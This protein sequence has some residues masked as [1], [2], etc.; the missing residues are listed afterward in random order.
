MIHESV[1]EKL[2]FLCEVFDLDHDRRIGTNDMRYVLQTQLH[3]QNKITDYV[4][5][6]KEK[7]SIELELHKLFGAGKPEGSQLEYADFQNFLPAYIDVYQ[8]LSIF[9]II[10][11]PNQEREIIGEVL[12]E[13]SRMKNDDTYYVISGGWYRAWQT[14]V[15]TCSA[16]TEFQRYVHSNDVRTPKASRITVEEPINIYQPKKL[17]A[18]AHKPKINPI[19]IKEDWIPPSSSTSPSPMPATETESCLDSAGRPG[20]IDNADLE[21][22]L[23]GSLKDGLMVRYIYHNAR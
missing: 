7:E 16:T 21:G 20:E 17:P 4:C 19:K 3:M 1:T 14:F 6:S 22:Y 8:M 15:N 12:R 23:P 5:S 2:H 13:N 9:Q 18:S 10:P 11:S